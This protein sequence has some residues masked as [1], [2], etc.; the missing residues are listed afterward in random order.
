MGVARVVSG[1]L[2]F[3]LT[4][5]LLS[6]GWAWH[7]TPWLGI[8]QPPPLACVA[9]LFMAWAVHMNNLP[10]FEIRQVTVE[11]RPPATWAEIVATAGT[12]P[13]MLSFL[14]LALYAHAPAG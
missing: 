14:W 13:L 3:L 11:E 12:L 9:L 8:P 10:S 4:I 5:V 1:V 2:T 7:I 6:T